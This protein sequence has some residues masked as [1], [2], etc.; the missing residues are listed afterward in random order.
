M[1]MVVDAKLRSARIIVRP[2]GIALA[3]IV[4]ALLTSAV[5]AQSTPARTFPDR[6][7]RLIVP[8]P[9][10]GGSDVMA[11]I[12][13]PRLS[14]GLGQPVVID[15]RAGAATI[16]GL[17][18]L[19]KSPPDGY[20]FGIATSTLAVNST[21]NKS[22]PFD[23]IRDFAPIMLA[24][25]GLYVLVIHPG[26]PAK[27]VRDLIALSRSAPGKLNAAI[28]GSGTPMHMGL[29]QFN[30]MVGAAIPG[31]IYKGAGPALASLLG[32]ETQLAFISMP[33]V[34]THI[35]AGKLRALAV[36]SERRSAAAPDLPTASE[37][38]LPGFVLSG[39]YGFLAP[40]KT[41]AAQINRL[42][43]E[44]R[45]ALAHPEV[46]RKLL[47]FGADVVAGAPAEFGAFLR[48]EIAKWGKVVREQ[49][50]QPE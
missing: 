26:V 38:G 44:L 21:L 23:T 40:A 4:G 32:G 28:A 33:T 6:P 34:V 12:L 7:L 42:N 2:R 14:E 45:T 22:L 48:A 20:T 11:R 39:W 16:I 30:S 37:A 19:A 50:I 25:D 31:V 5:F 24:A 41:G 36:T 10:G 43:A 46:K 35:H 1:P 49:N 17:D 18:L 29:A 3:A 15:N 13:A 8:Y 47:E 27:S 9:P